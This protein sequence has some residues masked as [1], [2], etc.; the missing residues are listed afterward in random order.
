MKAFTLSIIPLIVWGFCFFGGIWLLSLP[1]LLDFLEAKF[2]IYLFAI[3]LISLQLIPAML[4]CNAIKA[5]NTNLG[6][7]TSRWFLLFSGVIMSGIMIQNFRQLISNFTPE[8]MYF[9]LSG[10][11][12]ILFVFSAI[13]LFKKR[14]IS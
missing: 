14:K 4:I 10:I 8:S 1:A 7:K 11:I 3:L 9:F 13:L 2:L 12:G 6:H 5:C